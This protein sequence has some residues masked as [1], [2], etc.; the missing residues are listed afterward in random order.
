MLSGDK[1]KNRVQRKEINADI[2]R[3]C[4]WEQQVRDYYDRTTYELIKSQSDELTKGR[5]QLD[6]VKK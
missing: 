4:D 1:D 6:I 3:P 5:F 2:Y